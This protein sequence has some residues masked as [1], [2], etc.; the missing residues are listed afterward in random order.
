MKNKCTSLYALIF[1]ISL[2]ATNIARAQYCIPTYTFACSS[3]DNIN[4]FT[5]AGAGTSTISDL[6]TGCSSANY[7]NRTAVV[8]AINLQQGGT[9]SG[10]ITTDYF[11]NEYVRIWID[12]DNDQTFSNAEEV[13]NFGP[14][15]SFDG[16]FPF[17]LNVPFSAPVANGLRMRV[18][19]AYDQF[20][21][22]SID[23]C[24]TYDYG[25]T[26][27]YLVNIL[28]TPPCSGAPTAG[29]VSPAGPITD[30]AGNS[31]N[32]T[33]IGTTFAQGLTYQW[34][35]S[36]NGGAT[37]ANAVGGVGANTLHY[38]TPALNTTIWYRLTTTCGTSPSST[39]PLIIN[40][41]APTYAALPFTEGFESWM[42][43]CDVSNVP[44]ANW[45]NL[46]KTGDASWRRDDQGITA[47]WSSTGGGYIPASSGGSHSARFHGW[48]AGFGATGTLDAYVN[49]TPFGNKE[50]QFSYINPD[51]FDQL[52][53]LL[54]T[55]GGATFTLLN[56]YYN[57]T[58]WQFVSIPFTSTSAQ[59][60][61]RS[62]GMSDYSD[63][64]GLDDVKVLGPCAGMPTAGTVNPLTPCSGQN[65][66]LTLAGSTAASMLTYLWEESPDNVNWTPVPGGTS[67]VS[68]TSITAPT[69]FRCTVTCLMSTLSATTPSVLF[70]LSPFYHCYC[71]SYAQYDFDEDIGNVTITPSPSGAA[72][73]NNGT[74]TP[75]TF[76]PASVNTYTD[77]TALPPTALYKLSPYKYS[78]TQ[79][80]ENFFYE[81]YVGVYIDFNG[82]GVFDA[83]E[84]A[85]LNTTS[86]IS[87]PSQEV[88][89]TFTI[90]DSPYVGITGMRVVLVDGT[91][92]LP[93]PC[94][95]YFAGETE[96]YLVDIK[97][98]KCTGVPVVGLVH[99]SDSLLCVGDTTVLVDTTHTKGFSGLSTVWESSPDGTAWT[100]IA[101]SANK[102]TFT[103]TIP[104]DVYYRFKISCSFSG[105]NST[106][107]VKH[108]T[109]KAPYK[110]YCKSYASGGAN[111]ASDIG[112]FSVG[113]FVTN[114]GG[115]HLSNVTAI[116]PYTDYTDNGTAILFA[117]SSY[118]VSVYHTLKGASQIDAKVTMFIDFNNNWQY[119]L[120]EELVWTGYTDFVNT[121]THANITIPATAVKNVVTGMRV[122]LNNNVAP[123]V[124]SDEACGP[125]MSGETEDYIVLIKA[126]NEGVNN[127][128]FLQNLIVYPNP[129]EGNCVVAFNT[130]QP[131]KDVVISVTNI[132]GQQI[133]SSNY[134]DVA[135]QF[136]ENI[137]LS[138]Q[139]K[140][141]YFIEI[142]ADG[143]RT[144]KKI[145]VR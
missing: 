105:Q 144:V 143:E 60:I 66:N 131:L 118:Y 37:W 130:K 63:D 19:L 139:A 83:N 15:G 79:I 11:S 85:L 49:C 116:R 103:A 88:H 112:A 80:D 121:Y 58:S 142:K 67:F 109:L 96:D 16:I 82:N 126:K 68:T 6:N 78:V 115:P 12:F 29:T 106:S 31:Y 21:A 100:A 64:I 98:A 65:F 22:S 134:H 38:T 76:N 35:Q 20:P 24:F 108:V 48:D 28:L 136:Q 36:L 14:F 138:N 54:S 124:P 84:Q 8:P 86:D 89:N 101:G 145:V 81:A 92:Q 13:S 32:L 140:G 52:D 119:D 135:G 123:N 114:S 5:L 69:Y 74:A 120:P 133:Q 77:F 42:D 127:L 73:L 50:I 113:N 122:I 75:L 128:N 57:A 47:N 45:L 3:D 117:D 99:I 53:V 72:V 26:H 2:A 111:D 141:V 61:V 46:P 55:D 56:S 30:C 71:Q 33:T 1:I 59:T 18:R 97:P 93:D 87:S 90:P 27:D 137:N 41:N 70:N 129:T 102:D 95:N 62:R 104:G 34:E 125:Y 25:E 107:N 7:A 94:G 91:F 10:T 17:S 132:T 44:S 110:C 43:Y 23:P 40:I 39:A 9:Y 51:G 4:S